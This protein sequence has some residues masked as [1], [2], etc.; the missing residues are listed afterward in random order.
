M[1]PEKGG[2][3]FVGSD[4]RDRDQ[5]LRSS[6][7]QRGQRADCRVEETAFFSDTIREE[8]DN[9]IKRLQSRIYYLESKISAFSQAIRTLKARSSDAQEDESSTSPPPILHWRKAKQTTT[10]RMQQWRR[11]II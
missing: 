4:G 2:K 9:E 5:G 1:C 10:L 8:D 11:Y 7:G 3:T 6:G